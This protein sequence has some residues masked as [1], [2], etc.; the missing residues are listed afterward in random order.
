MAK[1]LNVIKSWKQVE[2]K[3]IERK[4]KNTYENPIAVE[5][6]RLSYLK[7][8][9][10][11]EMNVNLNQQNSGEYSINL[12]NNKSNRGTISSIDQRSRKG[13]PD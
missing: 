12:L 13:S 8:K 10:T 5:A 7:K 1:E 11:V 3:D 2:Q 9:N 4:I 6:K